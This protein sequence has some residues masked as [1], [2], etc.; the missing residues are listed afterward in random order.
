MATP[1]DLIRAKLV[2]VNDAASVDIL[3]A[4]S[5]VA[6][7]RRARA[8]LEAVPLVVPA[9]Y[10]AA[11]TLALA[12]YDER[13]DESNPVT[14]YTPKIIG[15]PETDWI[16]REVAKFGRT[17]AVTDAE[18][19]SA[20]LV[21]ETIRLAEKEVARGFR[22]S[23]TGNT[24]IDRD[25]IGWSRVAR[26][27]CCKFCAMIASRGAVFRESTA[28]FA[29]HRSCHCAAQ[30]EFAGG[31]HGPEASV[32]QYIATSPQRTEA[33]KAELRTY[34]NSNFPDFPG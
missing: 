31:V 6:P 9:Y 19:L 24:R 33:Q 27:G 15:D 2:Q 34:L 4:A 21:N 7:E 16:D 29:A 8:A 5:L 10:D 23:I 25:A 3:S 12:W 11:A 20:L 30:P 26:P 32:V 17:L 1:P 28:H 18:A 14:A 22:D 13:R